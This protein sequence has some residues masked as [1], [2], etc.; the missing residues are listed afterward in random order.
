MPT[1]L[2]RHGRVWTPDHP[3][4]TALVVGDD[5]RVVWLGDEARSSG[6]ADAVDAVVDLDGALVV[7]GFVDAHA[8]VSHTGLGV[9]GVDLAGTR[10]VTEALDLVAAAARRDPSRPVFAHG[11]QEQD[12]TRERTMTAAELDRASSGGVV[13]ASR[14]DGHS[15]VVSSALVALCGADS[16]DGWS[17]S[18]FVVRDAK[19]AARAAYDASRPSGERRADVEVALRAAAAQGIVAVHECGGPLLTSAEDFADVVDLGRRADLPATV[20][21]WAEAVTDPE[22]ARALVTL[23]G[24]RGLGGDLNIDGSIGS[25]TALL[26]DGYADRPD[27]HGTA[28][29]DVASVRDHVAACAVAGVQS[30]FHVIGDAGMDLVL[31]GYVRAA[32]LVGEDV[33][34]ASRP[35]LEHAEMV[36]AAGTAT[37][38]RLG[39]GASVQPAFDWYWGGR[40]GMYAER[41]GADRGAHTNLL[42]DL[43]AAGVRVGLGSDSPVTPFSPWVAVRAAVEHREPSQ[44]ISAEAA[45]EAHTVGGWSLAGERG[46]VL[47]VGA[48]ASFSAWDVPERGPGGLPV[49]GGG[50]PLPDCRLTVRSGVVLH[51]RTA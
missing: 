38:A 19:N 14:I 42:A 13:Y 27:C 49:L 36:D 40:E 44:R 1:T 37:M 45:L 7:P 17:E 31:E 47:S 11:W 22:Q 28:Y 9:R 29:R 23:H 30:G 12:W 32:E 24:A 50:A 21:Y 20:G 8:H 51:A 33:V 46:G 3:A 5:G 26:R 43:I 25:H 34:R 18:G 4:A 16:L 15:A 48:V 6:H 35:R 10:T 39:I 41:M 2:Y